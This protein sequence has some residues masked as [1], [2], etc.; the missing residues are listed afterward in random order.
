MDL[1]TILAWLKEEEEQHLAE[2]WHWA[3][4][5]RKDTVGGEVHLRGLVEFSNVCDRTCTYCGLRAG[6]R[7]LERYRMNWNEILECAART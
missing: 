4:T 3:D 5:V 7:R 6:N 1:D 2:L